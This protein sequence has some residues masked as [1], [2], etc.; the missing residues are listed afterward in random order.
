MVGRRAGSEPL[1]NQLYSKFA[2]PSISAPY[3]RPSRADGLDGWLLY[4]FHG[5][6]PVAQRL[7][8]LDGG[9]HMTTRRWFY[10]IPAA[11]R[12][13]RAGAQDRAPHA[14][15][16]AGHDHASTPAASSS[17]A[18][19]TTL[20]A[21]LRR[22]GDGVLADV[23]HPLRVAGRC[24]HHRAGARAAASTWSSS[25]DLVQQFEAMW[26]RRRLRA[27]TASRGRGSTA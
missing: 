23:R 14:G 4:D 1:A 19:L 2:C 21:G 6:N 9:G 24:R 10:L 18:G 15:A 12:A 3:K 5:S 20:L 25:G 16:P 27:R 7:A 22:G 26:T 8:G 13:A 11:R 17:R